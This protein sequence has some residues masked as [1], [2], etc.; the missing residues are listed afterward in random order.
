[1]LVTGAIDLAQGLGVSDTVIGLTVVAVGTSLPEL[2]ACVVAAIRRHSDVALGN[3]IGSNVYNVL[4]ILGVT[5]MVYPIRVPP[6]IARVDIWVMLA[7]TAALM[8]FMRTGGGLQRMEAAAF[9]IGYVA[10]V[11]FLA[12]GV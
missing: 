4:G 2:V 6:E 5:A 9:L 12:T 8:V 3:V 1:M 11:G 10:Y 7:A